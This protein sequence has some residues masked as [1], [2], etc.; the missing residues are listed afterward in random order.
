MPTLHASFFYIGGGYEPVTE[1]FLSFN[2][3]REWLDENYHVSYGDVPEKSRW[4][5]TT[6]IDRSTVRITPCPNGRYLLYC[7]VQHGY[8]S[9]DPD[10]IQAVHYMTWND[11]I[12]G[13]WTKKKREGH[14]L[15]NQVTAFIASHA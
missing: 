6:Y 4:N 13:R 5:W 9:R 3:L 10:E 1:E 7:T 8:L 15:A 2:D 14:Y 11:F 12:H